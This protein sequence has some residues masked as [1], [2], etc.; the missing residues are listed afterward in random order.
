[1][2]IGGLKLGTGIA[3]QATTSREGATSRPQ[4]E[5]TLKKPPETT[6][7]VETRLDLT[8]PVS[9]DNDVAR[10]TPETT[11]LDPPTPAEERKDTL[12]SDDVAKPELATKQPTADDG[13]VRWSSH[14]ILKYKVGRFR[15]ENGLLELRSDEDIEDFQKIHDDLPKPEQ[16]RIKKLDLSAAE[17]QVRKVLGDS[18]KASKGIG[19]DTGGRDPGKQVGKGVLGQS[20]GE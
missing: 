18:P 9:G 10:Q 17:A 16:I 13:V 2:N 7:E 5:S 14:P 4:P 15:F 20:H 12:E 11:F 19:S 6:D 3:N 1:M 8:K